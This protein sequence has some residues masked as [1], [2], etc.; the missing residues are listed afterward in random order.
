M[1]LIINADDFAVSE[2]INNAILMLHKMGIVK[3]TSIIAAG[4][5][6]DHAVEIAKDNQKLGIGVHLCLDGSFN[7]GKDYHSILNSTT[8]QFCSSSE[9]VKKL[10]RF[11]I[12]ESEVYRESCLQIEKVMDHHLKISHL[13]S[14]H[15]LHIYLPFLN[16]MIKAAK[17]YRIGYIRSQR[18]L[19]PEN[20]SLT[21]WFYRFCHQLYL[22]SRIKTIDGFYEHHITEDSNYEINFNRIF[23]LLY[24]KCSILEIIL[25]PHYIEDPETKFF[26]SKRVMNVLM[27]QNLISYHDLK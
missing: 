4:E 1:N 7:I 13:D 11:S 20:Q 8:Q 17:K 3:S 6:F 24:A 22:K 23:K 27:Q 16:C 10:K 14:H 5:N 9:I 25:H 12:D 21:N 15:H 19:S 18:V 26:S 2:N